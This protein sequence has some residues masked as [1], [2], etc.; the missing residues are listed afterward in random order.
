MLTS[1]GHINLLRNQDKI[2]AFLMILLISSL[3]RPNWVA[4]RLDYLNFL[5]FALLREK[6]VR[7]Y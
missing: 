7:N 5:L 6:F 4:L 3:I 1:Y 2:T